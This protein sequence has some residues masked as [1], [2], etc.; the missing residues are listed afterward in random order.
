MTETRPG[1]GRSMSRKSFLQGTAGAGAAGLVVGGGIGYGI[2]N[3]GSSSGPS[4]GTT[5]NGGS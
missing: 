2:G 4:G 5:G 3:S 1:G